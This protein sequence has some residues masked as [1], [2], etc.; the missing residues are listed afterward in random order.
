MPRDLPSAITPV[1]SKATGA[2]ASIFIGP[3]TT[4]AIFR[5]AVVGAVE[6]R[7]AP[8]LVAVLATSVTVAVSELDE[9]L[10]RF[11]RL[12][13]GVTHAWVFIRLWHGSR[14]IAPRWTAGR[15]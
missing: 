2:G 12:F 11:D 1:E 15:V 13:A 14:R 7:H 5:A 3:I 10:H 4:A 6:T 8:E 9:P